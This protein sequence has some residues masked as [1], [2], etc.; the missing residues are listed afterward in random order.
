MARTPDPLS[1]L[2]SSVTVNLI[3]L[4]FCLERVFCCKRVVRLHIIMYRIVHS[5]V[6]GSGSVQWV[7][8]L[9][10]LSRGYIASIAFTNACSGW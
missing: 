8:P 9:F 10:F 3:N 2:E 1:V 4:D 5:A 6:L 7:L